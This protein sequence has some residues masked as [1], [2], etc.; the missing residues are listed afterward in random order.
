MLKQRKQQSTKLF[1]YIYKKRENFFRIVAEP[2]GAAVSKLKP[3]RWVCLLKRLF[4]SYSIPPRLSPSPFLP[5]PR[6]PALFYPLK[7]PL[8]LLPISTGY[9]LYMYMYFFRI[10]L[11]YTVNTVCKIINRYQRKKKKEEEKNN[12]KSLLLY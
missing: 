6:Y 10:L 1:S 7:F 9:Y 4:F 11:R 3:L 12:L 5:P 2:F 8:L